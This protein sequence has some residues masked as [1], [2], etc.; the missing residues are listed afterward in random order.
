MLFSLF[1]LIDENQVDE[2]LIFSIFR[3]GFD[4]LPG[5]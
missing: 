4:A 2:F 3:F 5:H 1:L